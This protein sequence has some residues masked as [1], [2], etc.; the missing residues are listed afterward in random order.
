MKKNEEIKKER[1]KYRANIL[2]G[3]EEAGT[4]AR[5]ASAEDSRKQDRVQIKKEW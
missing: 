3:S 4:W 2:F 1:R 5:L